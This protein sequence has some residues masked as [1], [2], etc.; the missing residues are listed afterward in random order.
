MTQTAV[1]IWDAKRTDESR[2]VEDLLRNVGGF[3]QA[4]AYRYNSASI[5]VRVIDPR[6]EGMS[7]DQR[8]SMIEPYL[9]QLPDRTYGDIMTLYAFAPSEL[10]QTPQTFRE[11]VLN[12]EFDD[13][14]P[15]ML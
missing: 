3:A 2:G 14:S 7:L 9:K 10:V 11:Y 1:P 4:D 5:R 15:S 12:R 6:F 8:D 13:P